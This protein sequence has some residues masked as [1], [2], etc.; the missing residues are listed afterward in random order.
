MIGIEQASA[1]CRTRAP[2]KSS[3]G[4]PILPRPEASARKTYGGNPPFF[5]AR[6]LFHPIQKIPQPMESACRNRVQ[7]GQ[8][9]VRFPR[10]PG[11]YINSLPLFEHRPRRIRDSRGT[12]TPGNRYN[13][14][15]NLPFHRLSPEGSTG[16]TCTPDWVSSLRFQGRDIASKHSIYS[17]PCCPL[18]RITI[19]TSQMAAAPPTCSPRIS[20]SHGRGRKWMDADT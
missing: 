20:Y 9:M 3:M 12:S 13:K 18:P 15:S 5:A 2:A 17:F 7:G 8:R 11:T 1:L 10:S 19:T 14:L 6:D 16:F 4:K